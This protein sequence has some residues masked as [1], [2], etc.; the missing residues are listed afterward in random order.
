VAYKHGAYAHSERPISALCKL[1][2]YEL[3]PSWA[4]DIIG[5][6]LTTVRMP[7]VRLISIVD[8]TALITELFM[9]NGPIYTPRLVARA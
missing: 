7:F 6:V 3:L 1:G 5:L 8:L 4:L 2:L 9:C